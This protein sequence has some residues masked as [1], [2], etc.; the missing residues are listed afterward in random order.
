MRVWD[1]V[2]PEKLCDQHLLGE[3]REIHS[4]W[5]VLLREGTR[6]RT[7]YSNHPEVRRWEGHMPAL[8]KRHNR[9][10]REMKHRG[11]EH[12]SPLKYAKRVKGSEDDP[13]PW[14]DQLA[15]LREKGCACEVPE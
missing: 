2:P 5:G 9:L 7:G 1:Q 15:K 3:H 12:L 8:R 11:M 4:I 13:P 6:G 14:D 10:V